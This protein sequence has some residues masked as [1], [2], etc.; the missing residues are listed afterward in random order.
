MISVPLISREEWEAALRAFG[1][2]PLEGKTKLNTA[3]W[4]KTPWNFVFTVPIAEHMEGY[5]ERWSFDMLVT[6]IKETKSVLDP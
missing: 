2:K 4:W 1:C 5:M 6:R 3:E